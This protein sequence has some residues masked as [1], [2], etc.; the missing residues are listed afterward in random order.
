MGFV[1]DIISFSGKNELLESHLPDDMESFNLFIMLTEEGRRRRNRRV[2]MG[3]ESARLKFI[4]PGSATSAEAKPKAVAKATTPIANPKPASVP[5]PP[6]PALPKLSST[7]LKPST[8]QPAM[9]LP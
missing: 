1:K 8:Q 6:R 7:L 4:T 3:D 2:D 9:S 5:A